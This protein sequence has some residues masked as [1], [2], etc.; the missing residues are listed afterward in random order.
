[1]LASTRAVRCS[2]PPKV[3]RE[4]RRGGVVSRPARLRRGDDDG[5]LRDRQ[6]RRHRGASLTAWARASTSRRTHAGVARIPNSV[7][8]GVDARDGW[9]E[10][11][12]AL[13]KGRA[14][15]PPPDPADGTRATGR[16]K[17][18][19][20]NRRE[21]RWRDAGPRQKRDCRYGK[22]ESRRKRNR[23]PGSLHAA[24]GVRG[25]RRR[26]SALLFPRAAVGCRQLPHVP[27]RGEGRPA[28][29]G[30]LLR[31]GACG[32]CVPARTAKRRKSSRPRR[33]SRRR[34]KA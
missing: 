5:R 21:W 4:G 24:S 30:G 14:G 28:E 19:S 18:P 7:S 33:W 10:Q 12:K 8:R 26:G 20:G 22:A 25:G 27:R 2:P 6:A 15:H 23:S 9:V 1:V 31:H 32:T 34:A 17:A 13:A 11:A 29:A 3:A 16:A